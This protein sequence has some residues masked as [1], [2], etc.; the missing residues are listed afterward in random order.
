LSPRDFSHINAP[1]D[2]ALLTARL[3]RKSGGG[4]RE[5]RSDFATGHAVPALVGDMLRT[6]GQP[7][8]PC[9]RKGLEQ[10]LGH[11]FSSVRVHSDAMA[12]RSADAV[13][14]RAYTV[15]QDIVFAARQYAP[16]TYAGHR[17]LAHEL[18][19][20]AQQNNASNGTPMLQDARHLE[21]EANHVAENAVSHMGV[22]R[23]EG[24]SPLALQREQ[25]RPAPRA[26]VPS[27]APTPVET[28]Q[29]EAARVVGANRCQRAMF[30]AAGQSF[31]ISLDDARRLTRTL[32]DW[33]TP[34]MVAVRERLLG[35]FQMLAGRPPVMVAGA[36]DPECGSRQGY[37]TGG[38]MGA[39]IVLCPP[40]FGT[41]PG[42]PAANLA[43]QQART[44]IHE[45]AH[46]AGIRNPGPSEGYCPFYD[47]A[48]SCPNGRNDADS[49]SQLV[50][51]LS[52]QVADQPPTVVGRRRRAATPGGGAR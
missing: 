26:R 16:E 38:R 28:R 15:G 4:D 52:G 47:C 11:D 46:L 44:M 37:V 30:A 45:A 33:R 18:V 49:W 13:N 29:I 1:I 21:A 32:L 36:G 8:N 31:R 50:H 34:N 14:A 9:V 7:L 25:A 5:F 39:R 10:G 35:M 42:Q 2:E 3:Q 19:H 6:A 43:E 51:C 40:F 24:R 22:A 27:R 17:L 12:A 48:S 20:V 23:I 41:G